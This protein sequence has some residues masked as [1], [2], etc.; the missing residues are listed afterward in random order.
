MGTFLVF[1]L[2]VSILCFLLIVQN[3]LCPYRMVYHLVNGNEK[4]MSYKAR[5]ASK[6]LHYSWERYRTVYSV[7]GLILLLVCICKLVFSIMVVAGSGI[8]SYKSCNGN[9]YLYYMYAMM[10]LH[11]ISFIWP[12][13]VF[14]IGFI[15]KFGGVLLLLYCP[16]CYKKCFFPND[17]RE[18]DEAIEIAWKINNKED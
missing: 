7:V 10:W 18:V 4:Q 5:R 11:I 9:E 13:M 6:D 1:S 8:S 14:V 2:I 15:V 12:L 3:Y 17:S 16:G